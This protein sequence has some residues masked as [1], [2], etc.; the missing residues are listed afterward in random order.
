[1][2]ST[3]SLQIHSSKFEKKNKTTDTGEKASNSLREDG[4]TQQS[5]PTKSLQNQ[6]SKFEKKIKLL[7]QKRKLLT[8]YAKT[9]T[10]NRGFQQNHKIS[11]NSI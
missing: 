5:I 11:A 4:D 9:G 2:I 6:S 10:K 7:K 8:R 3:K 1:M